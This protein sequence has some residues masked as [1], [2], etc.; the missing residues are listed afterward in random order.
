MSYI[1]N[2]VAVQ[3]ARWTAMVKTK[4]EEK[5]RCARASH[6]EIRMRKRAVP[7]IRNSVTDEAGQLYIADCL[8]PEKYGT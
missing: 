7:P 5:Q 6:N 2:P 4:G 3:G 1:Q 8:K